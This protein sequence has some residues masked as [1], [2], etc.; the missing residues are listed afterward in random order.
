MKIKDI[1]TERDAPTRPPWRPAARVPTDNEIAG[2]LELIAQTDDPRLKQI[3]IDR[4][5]RFIG[6]FPE[7]ELP[8]GGDDPQYKQTAKPERPPRR[9]TDFAM[10][11]ARKELA[12]M[13]KKA[14]T[15]MDP[16]EFAGTPVAS[17][18]AEAPTPVAKTKKAPTPMDPEEF[19]GTGPFGSVAKP[20][21]VSSRA[22]DVA[23]EAPVFGRERARTGPLADIYGN[24]TQ[25]GFNAS[26][27]IGPPATD[28]ARDQKTLARL[29]A[30]Q[31]QKKADREAELARLK[32]NAGMKDSDYKT[33]PGSKRTARDK[34]NAG[35]KD[36]DYKTPP[37]SKRTAQD[38]ALDKE[39]TYRAPD[40]RRLK[41]KHGDIR[42][43][44]HSSPDSRAAGSDIVVRGGRVGK[45]LVDKKPAVTRGDDWRDK[46]GDQ[47]K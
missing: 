25:A 23:G 8:Y 24:E 28:P 10:D 3:Y 29:Q 46:V 5:E 31:A 17:A 26:V 20:E 19:A 33:P 34:A 27:G 7:S 16:E 47:G 13:P 42:N 4:F 39:Y 38:L 43:A 40:G 22:D 44:F 1:I 11:R 30:Q 18:D 37:G 15:P 35:M 9:A 36:S 2:A 32:A 21:K 45:R 6:K 12:D 14:P 41:Y